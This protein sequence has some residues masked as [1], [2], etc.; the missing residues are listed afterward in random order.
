MPIELIWVVAKK[1][2]RNPWKK[3]ETI[4]SDPVKVK[5]DSLCKCYLADGSLV[6]V[7]PPKKT[8]I[9]KKEDK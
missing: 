8:V 9:K 5:L 3:N 1:P 2:F 6:I 7:N 4:G